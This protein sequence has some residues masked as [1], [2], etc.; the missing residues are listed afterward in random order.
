PIPVITGFSPHAL[1]APTRFSLIGDARA[2][3]PLAPQIDAQQL[4]NALSSSD[5]LVRRDARNALIK[6]DRA[7]IRPVLD[8]L[9]KQP[10][11]ASDKAFEFYYVLTSIQRNN[12]RN[13]TEMRKPINDED[14]S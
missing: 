6:L 4:A 2:Q 7:A 12:E 9:R 10:D 13:S 5:Y 1:A 11:P 14:F 3:T 8:A